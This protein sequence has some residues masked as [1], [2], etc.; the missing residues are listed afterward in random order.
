MQVISMHYLMKKTGNGP[1]PC[2]DALFF[3][4][5]SKA[6]FREAPSPTFRTLKLMDS[7]VTLKLTRFTWHFLSMVRLHDFVHSKQLL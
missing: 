6:C 4:L 3:S 1:F 7:S 5:R 2:P